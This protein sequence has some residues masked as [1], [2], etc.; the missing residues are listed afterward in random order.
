MKAAGSSPGNTAMQPTDGKET[1]VIDCS[2]TMAWYFKDE[3]TP[4]TNA[5]RASL[6]TE[7]AVVPALWPLEVANVLLMGE[8]RKR[9]NQ[10][11]AT[12]WLRF[13][14]SLPIAIDGE[15]PFRTFDQILNLARAQK[16]TTYDAAYLELAVRRSLPLGTLDR[17][18]EKAARAVGVT[19]Y[20]PPLGRDGKK[21]P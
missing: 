18:L 11:R 17:V 13:L 6:T 14:S 10:M 15:T 16:L 9:S 8:R 19:I 20:V 5:V 21:E 1:L 2:L 12:K 3:A 4:Y 7:R